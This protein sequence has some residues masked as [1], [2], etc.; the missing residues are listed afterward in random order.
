MLYT[1]PVINRCIYTSVSTLQD[2]AW[3]CTVSGLTN[4]RHTCPLLWQ[5]FLHRSSR[6]RGHDSSVVIGTHYGLDAPK[7]ESRWR[8]FPHPNQIGNGAHTASCKM[9]TGSLSRVKRPGHGVNHPPPSSAEVK[10]RV[11]LYLYSL[12]G[13]SW[14][15]LGRTLRFTR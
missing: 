4:H 3:F 12:S 2:A 11:E 9:G 7:I 5:I 14:P 8:R 1:Y 10:E 6:L 13:L 15:V